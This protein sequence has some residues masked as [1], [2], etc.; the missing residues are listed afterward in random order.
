MANFCTK[1]G[2]GLAAGAQFC[3]A[4]GTSV[5]GADAPALGSPQPAAAYAQPAAPQSTSALKV[6]LIVLAVFVGMGI[7]AGAA[8]VFGVWRLSRSVDV[9]PAGKVRISTPLGN[10]TMGATEVSEAELGVAIYPGARREQGSLQIN[11]AEGSLGTYVFKTS[12][13]PAQV[14]EFYR[15]KL[16]ENA[17]FVETLEGA[18]ITS[19]KSE[20]EG[21][22]I[23]VG[24]DQDDS[25]PLISII[26]G[27]SPKAP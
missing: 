24:R 20:Q 21:F 9:D 8:I 17:A 3:T 2:S 12:D 23:T 25:Q 13:S 6:I 22:M 14:L 19:E 10:M 18:M 1:C 16:G 7:L 4:C 11:T 5:G 15:G 26:R 27:R